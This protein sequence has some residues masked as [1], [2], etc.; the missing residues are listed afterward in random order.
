MNVLIMSCLTCYI[1]VAGLQVR[2]EGRLVV[3]SRSIR[4]T[5][6]S[7]LLFRCDKFIVFVFQILSYGGYQE[8]FDAIISLVKIY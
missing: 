3:Q 1:R 4:P 5:T 2:C 7:C 6:R 8:D